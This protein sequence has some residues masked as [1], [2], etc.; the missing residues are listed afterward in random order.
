MVF[1][2]KIPLLMPNQQQSRLHYFY[3]TSQPSMLSLN[4]AEDDNSE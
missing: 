1:T 3:H 2:V 4:V